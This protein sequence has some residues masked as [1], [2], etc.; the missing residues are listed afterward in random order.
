MQAEINRPAAVALV[1]ISYVVAGVAAVAVG[2]ALLTYE[3]HPLTV[4]LAADLVA[5]VVIFLFSYAFDNSSFYDAYWSVIPPLIGVYLATRPGPADGRR[6]AIVI[7]LVTCWAVRLTYNWYRGWTGLDHEDWRYVDMRG[8]SGRAYWL[9]S[10]LGIHLFP[11]AMVFV[12]CLA[13]Y[14]AL[15][16]GSRALGWLDGVAVLVTGGAIV[17]EGVA[18]QQLLRF[19]GTAPPGK[20]LAQGLWAYSRHPNYFGEMSFWWGVFLF[21]MAADPAAWWT[22]AGPFAITLMF[23]FASIPMIDRRMLARRPGYAERMRRVPALV[24]WPRRA[25]WRPPAAR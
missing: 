17:I 4:V 11:T 8:P 10:F 6:Q 12:A 13:L 16:G 22:I 15:V 1:V 25:I 3:L 24:P 23:V 21:G 7:A 9:V 20:T 19:R 5:T 2:R 14:P 18:D